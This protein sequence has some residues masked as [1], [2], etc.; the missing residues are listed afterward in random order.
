MKQ[1]ELPLPQPDGKPTSSGAFTKH[2][3]GK[4]RMALLDPFFLE[5]VA[6]VLT[7]GGNLYSDYN[8]Q[9]CTTPWMT[10]GSA[11]LRHF[12]AVG[13]GERI[14]PESGKSHWYHIGCCCMFLAWFEREGKL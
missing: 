5:G 12:I 14:D 10:Y 9:N 8:W 7:H 2:D 13:K 1:L 3:A 6:A 4:I 11:L